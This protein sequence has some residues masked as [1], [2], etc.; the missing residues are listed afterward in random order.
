MA[1]PT[2]IPAVDAV[3]GILGLGTT[4]AG[5]IKEGETKRIAQQLAASRPQYQISPLAGQDLSFAQSELAS[6][7]SAAEKAYTDLNNGQFSSSLGATLRSGGTP[8][9]VGAIYGNNEDGRLKLQMMRDNLRLAKIQNYVRANQNMQDQ[10]TTQW[11]VNKFAPWEDKVQ[12]NAAAREGASSMVNNG[13]NTFGAAIG[14]AGQSAREQK[15]FS[16]PTYPTGTSTSSYVSSI[17]NTT[18]SSNYYN[19]MTVLPEQ[20]PIYNQ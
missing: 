10:Q 14:N 18:S 6:N 16:L 19:P 9:S 12:A 11:Q 1:T 3:Q 17:P 4:V 2:G 5:L 13:L 8:N 15:Q 7:G 20:T